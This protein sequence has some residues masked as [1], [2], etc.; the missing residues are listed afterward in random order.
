MNKIYLIIRRE[1]LT[2]VRKKSFVVMTILGPL[3]IAT[4]IILPALLSEWSEAEEKRVAVLDE[5]GIFYEQFQDQEN[6]RFYHVYEGLDDEKENAL[7]KR[8]DLLLYIPMTELSLPVHAELFSTRQ[9]GLN[10]T[11]YIRSVMKRTIEN[12]KLK[13]QGIDPEMIK[14]AQADINLNTIRVE[15]DGAEKRSFT[16]VEVGLAIVA[17]I[18]IYFF[19]FMFGAQVLKGVMEEKSSRIVEVIISSVRPFQLMMGKIIGIAMVGLTQFLLWILLTGFIL[20]LFQAGFGADLSPGIQPIGGQDQLQIDQSASGLSGNQLAMITEVIGSINLPVM[21]MSFIFYFLGGYLL[22]SSL[23]AA[24]GGAVDH[25]SDTQQFMLPVSI[26]LVFSVIMSG[27][28][29]NQPD[30]SLALWLSM[31][32]F[33]SPVIMMMRIPFG[34]PVWEVYL[35]GSILVLGFVLTTWMAGKIYRTGILMYG[36]KVNYAVMWKWLRQKS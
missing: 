27:V 32:P 17:G 4:M 18:M 19:I 25:D 24:I 20:I 8:N 3:L 16:E 21:I 14:S 36:Q 33:T 11:A 2:R 1:Y 35:S 15:E 34:V 26:P 12:E 29:V 28:I 5:T 31:I 7:Y 10:V 13:A 6:I 23:F 9:P 30:S 22:Y